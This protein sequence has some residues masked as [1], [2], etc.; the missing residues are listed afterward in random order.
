MDDMHLKTNIILILEFI[1]FAGTILQF[2]D[3]DENKAIDFAQNI[4]DQISCYLY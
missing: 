4:L 2:I 3:S 1:F